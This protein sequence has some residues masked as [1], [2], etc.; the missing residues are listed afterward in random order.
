MATS[1][2]NIIQVTQD[3]WEPRLGYRPTVG[4]AENMVLNVTSLFKLLMEWDARDERG[5]NHDKSA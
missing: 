1:H 2:S 5:E 4:E 3:F